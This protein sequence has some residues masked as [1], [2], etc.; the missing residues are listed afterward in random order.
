[1]VAVVGFAAFIGLP[2]LFKKLGGGSSSGGSAGDVGAAGGYGGYYPNDADMY[3]TQQSN[4]LSSLLNSLAQALSS[5]N[6][7]GGHGSQAMGGAMPSS[8]GQNSTGLSNSSAGNAALFAQDQY[9][10]NAAAGSLF[11]QSQAAIDAAQSDIYLSPEQVQNFDVNEMA[12]DIDPEDDPN[13]PQTTSQDSGY[14]GG[15]DFDGGS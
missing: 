10:A 15:D 3:G 4:P 2:I 14:I 9:D 6:S 5:G 11:D 8:I 12:T 7:S 1:M 13:M